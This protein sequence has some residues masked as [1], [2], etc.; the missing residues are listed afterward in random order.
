MNKVRAARIAKRKA[1]AEWAKLV[2][3]RDKCCIICDS[4]ERLNA[5]HIIPRSNKQFALDL[6]NGL[7]CC[8]LHHKFSYDISAHKNPFVF[9]RWIEENKPELLKNLKEKI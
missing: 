4:T 2:K 1:F 3:A 9:Y 7:T 6:D 5:H 8:V